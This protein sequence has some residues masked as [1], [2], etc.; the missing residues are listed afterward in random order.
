MAGISHRK[1]L[2]PDDADH[3]KLFVA[4]IVVKYETGIG[5]LFPF[6]L[7]VHFLVVAQQNNSK[8]NH[9]NGNS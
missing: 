1:G 4:A 6:S 8:Y 7:I 3:L 9:T 2:E 5:K